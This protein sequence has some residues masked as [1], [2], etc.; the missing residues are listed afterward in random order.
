MIPDLIG[1]LGGWGWWIAGVMLLALELAIPGNVLVWFGVAA[2]LTGVLALMFEWSWQV[3]L[4]LFIVLSAVLL[5]AGRRYFG[6]DVSPGEQP[7]LNARAMRLVGGT[8]VLAQPIVDGHGTIRID[9]SNW[10]ITGPDLP[11]GT[12][13]RVSGVNGT[14][15]SVEESR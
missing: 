9:D 4:V 3:E 6:R 15:L 5:I 1:D 2:I 13:V 7:F 11:S 8:Y 14:V 12:K 10:R